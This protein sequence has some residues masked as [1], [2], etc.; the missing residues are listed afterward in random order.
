MLDLT[1]RCDGARIARGSEFLRVDDTNVAMLLVSALLYHRC[2]KSL[3]LSLVLV[4]VA[5]TAADKTAEKTPR[6]RDG[7]PDLS[8]NWSYATLT[9]LERP[10]ELGTRAFLTQAEAAEF[11]KR[12]LETQNRDRRDGEG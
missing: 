10:T 5:V 3:V 4:G 8:G 7:H 1:A 12:I 2:M 6:M 9:T 11:E